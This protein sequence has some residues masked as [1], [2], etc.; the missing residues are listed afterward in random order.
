[1]KT[2]SILGVVALLLSLQ[3]SAWS[4]SKYA[5][6]KIIVTDTAQ[7]I[8][9]TCEEGCAWKTLTFSCSGKT[10]CESGIDEFGMN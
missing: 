4:D 2:L 3:G 1:M 8:E 5:H 7:G 10:P 9:L 6:F